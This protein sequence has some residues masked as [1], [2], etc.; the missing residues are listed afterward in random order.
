MLFVSFFSSRFIDCFALCVLFHCAMSVQEFMVTSTFM[1]TN[2]T[3]VIDVLMI[4]IKRGRIGL[5][6]LFMVS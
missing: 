1:Y 4:T 5:C 3:V 6:Y 2:V